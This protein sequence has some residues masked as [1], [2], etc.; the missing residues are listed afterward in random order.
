MRI[1]MA[2]RSRFAED[3]L[4]LAVAR[5]VRQAVIGGAGLDTF[6]MRNPS[7]EQGLRV[8][9]VDHP[10]TQA[11]KRTR[12]AEVGLAIPAWL[13]FVPVDLE[14]Q[15]LSSALIAAGFELNRPAF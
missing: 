2:A 7:R 4:W 3:H 10:A 6:S 8:F 1:F 5:G 9:E 13:I 11:W 15:G 14:E 12:L